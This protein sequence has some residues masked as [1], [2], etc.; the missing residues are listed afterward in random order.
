MCGNGS[1]KANYCGSWRVA[2]GGEPGYGPYRTVYD[3]VV[4]RKGIHDFCRRHGL[5]IREEYGT[6]MYTGQ[7]KVVTAIVR[8]Y[9]RLMGLLSLGK[10]AC[11]HNPLTYVIQKLLITQPRPCHADVTLT[12]STLPR[13]P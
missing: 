3:A 4:S 2:A 5:L 9:V 13:T 11:G 10:L 12:Q 8:F 7:A 1:Y 6:A